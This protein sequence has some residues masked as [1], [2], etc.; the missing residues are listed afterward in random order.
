MAETRK[1]LRC[2]VLICGCRDAVPV[3]LG[4]SDSDTCLLFFFF[5][6]FASCSSLVVGLDT[7]AIA[8]REWRESM[9]GLVLIAIAIHVLSCFFF[10]I[11]I[12]Q[13]L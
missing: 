5:F 2:F 12:F 7:L 1:I 9:T 6:V 10:R 4:L 13:L 11:T 8:F 3:F